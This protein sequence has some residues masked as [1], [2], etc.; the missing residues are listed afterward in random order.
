MA[1]HTFPDAAPS[2][3]G[4][5]DEA[6]AYWDARLRSPECTREDR[7]AYERWRAA[8]AEN[9]RE[10]E[11][12]QDII[13]ALR[14]AHSRP[15]ICALREAALKKKRRRRFLVGGV[16]AA[17][18]IGLIV[19]GLTL[20]QPV[21]RQAGP[22]RVAS[23]ET[24]TVIPVAVYETAV[25]ERKSFTLDD[26]SV[27]TLDTRSRVETRFSRGRRDLTLVAGQASF[28]VAHDAS[29]P[30]VVVAG[31]R[32]VTALGTVFDVRLDGDD[33]R[34]VVVQGR[35]AVQRRPQG[36][37]ID[38]VLSERRELT[39]GQSYST[40]GEGL[41]QP[42]AVRAVDVNETALWQEGRVAFNDVP[43]PEAVAEMNRYST[44]ALVVADPSMRK[45]R[46]SGVFRTDQSQAFVNAVKEYFPIEARKQPGGDTLLVWRGRESAPSD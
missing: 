20:Q 38:A 19:V 42:V 11:N 21:F 13:G 4:A 6:A 8:D 46:I 27:L 5:P 7:E 18:A 26:G 39:P 37:I 34:V 15:M 14:A 25:G 23:A 43:L 31:D 12:L 2:R 16:A 9:A 32:Q 33:V 24:T 1:K 44:G 29:R 10:F 35:V 41:F 45:L 40:K 36:R 17:A 22:S 28:R 3:E 30:F